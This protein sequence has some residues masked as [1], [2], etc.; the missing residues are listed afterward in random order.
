MGRFWL[1]CGILVSLLALSIFLHLSGESTHTAI[2]HDLDLAAD[3]I[4]NGNISKAHQLEHQAYQ[5]WQKRWCGTA[6]ATDHAPMDEIDSL[7]A[8]LEMYRKNGDH[9]AFAAYCARISI[10]V[11][12]VGEC[13]TIT[14][15]NLLQYCPLRHFQNGLSQ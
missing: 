3:A 14:W 15:W 7:F 1:G 6:A 5:T 13:Q 2:S 12:A 9:S 10:L 8:A 4:L 11:E